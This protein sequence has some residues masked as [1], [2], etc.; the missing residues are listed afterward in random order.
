MKELLEKKTVTLQIDGYGKSIEEAYQEI[1][2]KVRR[3]IHAEIKGLLVEMHIISCKLLSKDEEVKIKKFL[4]FF[5]PVE[6]K[7][8][9]IKCELE[10]EAI[11]LN[12]IEKEDRV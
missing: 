7:K 1:F 4:V 6:H 12:H 8:Y 2:N 10:V 5:M 3:E 9:V 11:V